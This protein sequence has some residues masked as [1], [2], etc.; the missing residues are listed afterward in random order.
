MNVEL[1]E[2]TRERLETLVSEGSYSSVEAAIEA[3]VASLPY[4]G[5][6]GVDVEGLSAQAEASRG[7]KLG[8][9][10]D[11][12]YEAELRAKLNATI[13]PHRKP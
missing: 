4:S 10:L 9:L 7:N 2:R 1:S 13:A 5:F 3:A 12:G 8:R 6:D 11:E